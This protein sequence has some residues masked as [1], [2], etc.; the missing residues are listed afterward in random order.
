[1]IESVFKVL[2]LIIRFAALLVTVITHLHKGRQ[3]KKD[4]RPDKV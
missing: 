1:M 4:D 2:D 3:Y